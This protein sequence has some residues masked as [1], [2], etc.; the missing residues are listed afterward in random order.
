LPTPDRADPG[1]VY[2]LYE[3]GKRSLADG[4]P[5][6]AV[7]VLELAIEHEPAQASLREALGRAY[8]ATQRPQL[9][10]REFQR[11][12][13]L[14]PTDHYAHFGIGRCYEREGQLPDAAK[15]FKVACALADRAEYAQALARVQERLQA[16]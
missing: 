14:E 15:H 10:R 12:A 3:Q 2:G 5:R 6:G 4:N 8:F 7:E 1:L 13:E 16:P 9:A 11:A